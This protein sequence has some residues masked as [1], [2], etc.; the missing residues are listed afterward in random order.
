MAHYW[1]MKTEPSECSIQDVLSFPRC[2]VDW[3][4]IRN[5]QA[6]NFLR[7]DMAPGDPVLF[8]HSSCPHPGIVGLARIASFAYPDA[9]QFNP[10]SPYFDAKSSQENPR[11][12]TIDVQAIREVPLISIQELRTHKELA[13]MRLLAKGNRLSITPVTPEEY[14]FIT[15]HLMPKA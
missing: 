2:I 6:R 13:K 14:T 7:D 11:W 3:W 12:L 9:T 4:G 1:L 15:E 10:E 8:Y 5:Y